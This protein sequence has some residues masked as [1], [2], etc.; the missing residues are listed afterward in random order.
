MV[1]NLNKNAINGKQWTTDVM[2]AVVRFLPNQKNNEEFHAPLQMKDRTADH[3]FCNASYINHQTGQRILMI[4][5][6]NDCNTFRLM[7]Q[8]TCLS[9]GVIGG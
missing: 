5:P 4:K 3:S 1:Y 6:R 2:R 9:S 7:A 8:K